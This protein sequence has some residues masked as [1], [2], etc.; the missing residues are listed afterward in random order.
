MLVV[1]NRGRFKCAC[2]FLM[3]CAKGV[4]RVLMAVVM[5]AKRLRTKSLVT[6]FELR[7]AYCAASDCA[8]SFAT[9]PLPSFNARVMTPISATFSVAKA[10]QLR[11][12]GS[13]LPSNSSDTGVCNKEHDVPTQRRSPKLVLAL[14]S[15]P[16]NALA[17]ARQMLRP[18]M[19]PIDSTL[20]AGK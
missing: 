20:S 2:C 1:G 10:N 4:T 14:C 6:R 17:S 11:I 15:W 3:R 13:S 12:S 5:L 16:I 8:S 18:S 9:A 7:R 19:M